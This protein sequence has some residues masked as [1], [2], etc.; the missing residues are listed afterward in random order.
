MRYLGLLLLMT[1]L[2]GCGDETTGPATI[3]W[4]R[5]VCERCR[6][7]ISDRR[8]P[9]QARDAKGRAHLFDD[10]GDMVMWLKEQ[11]LLN[12]PVLLY[13]TDLESGAWLDARNARYSRGHHT[14]MG[15]GLAAHAKG[16]DM[17][18]SQAV[19]AILAAGGCVDDKGHDH[20]QHPTPGPT[21]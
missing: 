18:F 4:D 10:F 2:A 15:F 1:V 3:H 12:A 11:D 7:M 21:P 20:S 6:M 13:V 8:F 9:A 16:G 19:S 17:D 5:D 14:P